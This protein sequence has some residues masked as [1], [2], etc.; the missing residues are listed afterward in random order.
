MGKKQWLECPFCGQDVKR[1]NMDDHLIGVHRREVLKRRIP[2]NA[3]PRMREYL[4]NLYEDISPEGELG[5]EKRQFTAVVAVAVVA[6][7]LTAGFAVYLYYPQSGGR[8]GGGTTVVN[9]GGGGGSE[10]GDSQGGNVTH[11]MVRLETTRGNIEIEL[12]DDKAP[13]T[14]ENFLKY[15]NDGFYDGLIFHRVISGFMIQ[16]G[17]F[18]P[19]MTQK[20]PTYPPIV[21]EAPTN[22]LRNKRG[23][24]AMARTSDPNSATSQFFINQVEND[25]LDWDKAQDGY[26][27]AVF[28]RVTVG[29]DVVDDIAGVETHSE[30]GYDDV[31]VNDIII[32]R[33][34][35]FKT[36]KV[37]AN[38]YEAYTR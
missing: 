4:M 25:F 14:V 36:I 19:D 33:A 1:S 24:I 12:F 3:S 2:D 26:G 27:Y 10:G 5:V 22:H 34:Y 6:I 35:V 7:L 28:G 32:S 23:T 30:N 11:T 38:W 16:G 9:N 15:V 20:P 31:P 8:G 37:E 21:N 29:M 13:I 17:G 18:Y